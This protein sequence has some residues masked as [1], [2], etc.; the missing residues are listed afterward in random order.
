MSTSDTRVAPSKPAVLGDGSPVIGTRI[1]NTRL[2]SLEFLRIGPS[3]MSL[4]SNLRITEFSVR[5]VLMGSTDAKY[6][7]PLFSLHYIEDIDNT[8][9]YLISRVYDSIDCPL[10]MPAITH[11]I[12]DKY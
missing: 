6:S 9:D 3:W 10:R 7:H 1:R 8:Q 5:S 4:S 2:R 11:I 12:G